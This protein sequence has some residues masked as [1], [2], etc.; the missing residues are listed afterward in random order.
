MAASALLMGD[1]PGLFVGEPLQLE[2]G[3]AALGFVEAALESEHDAFAAFLGDLAVELMQIVATDTEPLRHQVNK[4]GP[5]LAQRGQLAHALLEGGVDHGGVED[6]VGDPAPLRI[7]RNFAPHGGDRVPKPPSSRPELAVEDHV[8]G[9][10]LLEPG[11]GVEHI[12]V[13]RPEPLA[14]PNGPHPVQLL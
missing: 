7:I 8:L 2:Q 6:L 1:D 5:L 10:G 11:R 14:V 4:V 3:G 13:P 9:K 12:P